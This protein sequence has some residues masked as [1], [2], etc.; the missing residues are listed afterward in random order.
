M[1]PPIYAQALNK[2]WK[3]V[4]FDRIFSLLVVAFEQ[5]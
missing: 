1:A 4:V 3:R 5:I 2:D